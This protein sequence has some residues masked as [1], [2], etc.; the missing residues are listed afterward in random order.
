MPP[1]GC[2]SLATNDQ[3]GQWTRKIAPSSTGTAAMPVKRLT[4][5]RCGARSIPPTTA[6]I[7][8]STSAMPTN[9]LSATDMS[10]IWAEATGISSFPAPCPEKVIAK[11]IRTNQRGFIRHS[12]RG[13]LTIDPASGRILPPIGEIPF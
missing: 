8:V 3:R 9:K 6:P 4:S 2:D 11:G 10:S 1:N 7:P 13:R 12:P 5:L